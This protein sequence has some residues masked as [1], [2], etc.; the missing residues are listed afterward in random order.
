M[1]R[2]WSGRWVAD[3]I[4]VTLA[5]DSHAS[6][7]FLTDL[8]GL[9]LRH[10][11]RRAH[12][13]VSSVL[14]KHVPTDPEIVYGAAR[15][16]GALVADE[17]ACQRSGI[18][19]AGGAVLKS[20]LDG[21][22]DHATA[23][24]KLCAE[25][26]EVPRAG[27][28]ASAESMT[29]LGYAETATALGHAVADALG[30][31]Y[32]HSTRRRLPGME[33]V[34]GFEEEHSH[35]THHL[36][37]PE[38][39]ELLSRSGPLVLVDDEL[40]T[41][42]T[43]LNTI[44]ALHTQACRSRYVIAALVDLRSSADRA[45]TA[46]LAAS[47]GVHIDVVALA[48]GHVE[49]PA[50]VLSAGQRLV[51][52]YRTAGAA[53]SGQT[54]ARNVPIADWYGVREG[55][56]HGFSVCD[57]VALHAATDRAAGQIS[58]QLAGDCVL[59]LGFEELMYAPLLIAN[60]LKGRLKNGATVRF[61]TTTRSPVLTVDDPG[62]AIRT[63]LTF[64][65]HD[66]PIDGPGPRFAY[67]VAPGSDPSRR[68]TDIVFVVDDVGDT[69]AL[70]AAGGLLDQLAGCCDQVH[71]LTLPSYRPSIVAGDTVMSA[72]SPAAPG[73]PQP[74]YGPDFG[75]YAKDEVSWLLTDLSDIE[76]ESP[77]EE[78]E[79]AVQ[80]G[81][82]H[83]AESLPVEYQPGVAYHQLF[84]DALASSAPR[85]AHAVG[86]VTEMALAERGNGVVLVSLARA[87]T[88][89]GVL[90]RRW[91]RFAHDL[92]VPHYALS[93]VRGR[94][95]DMVALEYLANHHDPTRIM[96]VD[97]WT[98]KGAITREL[99]EAIAKANAELGLADGHGFSPDIAVLADTGRCVEIYGTREDYLI[100]SACLNSTVSG[101]VSR[102]VLNDDLIGP[103]QFHGAKF[104]A[105]LAGVDVSHQF[106]DA[107][108]AE[109]PTVADAVASDWPALHNA[110]RSP[111]W[112]GW[113]AVEAIRA[114]Y[115]INN[116]NLV[117]PGV[118]E[119]TRVLLRRVPWKILVRAGEGSELRHVRM[120]AE[121]RGVG[122][123]L[124]ENLPYRCVGLIQPEF[125]RN[126]AIAGGD[127][128]AA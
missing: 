112:D 120:L 11:P 55:G 92:D 9:A 36:L 27:W 104:Y 15:L 84:S 86:V 7:L 93:I 30:V 21:S 106:V 64:P 22:S 61:S 110:D 56:R 127:S 37:L 100:P 57:R 91:A 72:P 8:V 73:L 119:T 99:T 75:S 49:L 121:Q 82:A 83:Y 81:R 42:Q 122:I 50:G 29:V 67:N 128:A 13:L 25:H 23:L 78:R 66:D 108:T 105:H 6:P 31:D 59:V 109:F 101:L 43:A 32:L 116:A 123:E 70:H 28:Q 19:E 18:A 115:G 3:R 34:G 47:L 126:A 60:R 16:L 94:G 1:S 69:D 107:I 38:D 33:E 114:E 39:R 71:L 102:T 62:Y 76:L 44:A 24:L 41:G 118:G 63:H 12:L 40:S 58:A 53:P 98:G 117:K 103:G 26:A 74:L 87:G 80:S 96:F 45:R 4:N 10:N 88:P 46:S 97:G 48:T 52:A 54:S 20:A 124:V 68:F 111:T 90:M 65:S 14:G 77:T 89:V 113:S 125:T 5:T 85:L 17:I 51:T 79:E 2:V 35:A 95:I